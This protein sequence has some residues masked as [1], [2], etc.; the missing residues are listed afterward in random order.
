MLVRDI[1][2]EVNSFV[3]NLDLSYFFVMADMHADR[4]MLTQ[5]EPL[6]PIIFTWLTHGCE[7]LQVFNTVRNPK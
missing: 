2:I 1:L 4:A 7:S 6:D 3:D 5:R